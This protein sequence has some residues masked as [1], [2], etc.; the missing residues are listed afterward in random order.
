MKKLTLMLLFCGLALF[1]I[2]VLADELRDVEFSSADLRLSRDGTGVIKVLNCDKGVCKKILVKVTPATKGVLDG[3]EMDLLQ[4]KSLSRPGISG[5]V[6]SVDT[7]EVLK[8][9]FP[10]K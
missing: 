8:I 1:D 9:G 3:V 4:A 6:Y 2:Q 5:L 7:R 10:H